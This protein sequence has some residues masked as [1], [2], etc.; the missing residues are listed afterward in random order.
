MS[1][2]TL[3]QQFAGAVQSTLLGRSVAMSDD[4]TRIVIGEQNYGSMSLN[5][6]GRALI[7]DYSGDEMTGM[8]VDSGI[9]TN[10]EGENSGDRAGKSVAISADG[11]T[12]AISEERYSLNRGR[13]RIFHLVA[14]TW[15]LK[16]DVSAMVGENAGDQIGFNSI[17]LNADGTRIIIGEPRYMGEQGRARI[18]D[19][20]GSAWIINSGNQSNL[21]G[22][23]TLNDNTG[24][25]VDISADGSIV[26]IGE[27]GY[28][29]DAGRARVF[30]LMEG[31][32][33]EL[34]VN[35][36][37]IEGSTPGDRAGT[38]I[39]LSG[40]G[41]RLAVGD[42]NYNS[43]A[44]RFRVFDYD[45]S[46]WSNAGSVNGSN[47]D[48]MGTSLSLTPDGSK[49]AVG[50]IGYSNGNANDGRIR[51][52][53]NSSGT[54]WDSYPMDNEIIPSYIGRR[55]GTSVSIS[56]NGC[57]LIG[58]APATFG[59]SFAQAYWS[60][61]G[62]AALD[63]SFVAI[64]NTFAD[65][66]ANIACDPKA[67]TMEHVLIVLDAFCELLKQKSKLKRDIRKKALTI[68]GCDF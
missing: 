39:S 49:L 41:T 43:D 61:V 48:K 54:T 25:S 4:G 14:G 18:F 33:T 20:D 16:G 46:I 47:V 30:Q 67:D 13:V 1:W 53:I 2:S 68:D 5:N 51:V 52:F 29:N 60:C 27:F 66:L 8:W 42:P 63:C 24:H 50:E 58:G 44:G 36:S 59:D 57:R 6:N 3:G 12:V 17:A 19:Y 45:G 26:A 37:I 15:V 38:A 7:L 55:L 11:S 22:T 35:A 10:L 56:A 32:W 31:M 34:S 23:A 64:A 21:Y 62:P 65:Y 9:Y 40:D 28:N